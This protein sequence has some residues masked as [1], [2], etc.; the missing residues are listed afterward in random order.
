VYRGAQTTTLLGGG[1]GGKIRAGR[2]NCLKNFVLHCRFRILH[3]CLLGVVGKSVLENRS[4][5]W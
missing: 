5:T 4:L 2:V 1:G 3:F